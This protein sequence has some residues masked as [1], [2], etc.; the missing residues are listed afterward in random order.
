MTR[1][2]DEDEKGIHIVNTP[3]GGQHMTITGGAASAIP[4]N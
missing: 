2:L 4:S 1:I 3:G